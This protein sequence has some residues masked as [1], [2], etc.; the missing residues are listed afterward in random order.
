MRYKLVTLTK[1]PKGTYEASVVL[2]PSDRQKDQET[3][4]S[5]F[6]YSYRSEDV[7]AE[8]AIKDLKKAMIDERLKAIE[9]LQKD[10]EGI[11]N[12]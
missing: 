2:Q 8:D 4:N 5:C 1:T 11:K 6:G 12:A 3:T 10:I 9:K 7:S